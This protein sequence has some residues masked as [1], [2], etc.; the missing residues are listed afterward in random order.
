MNHNYLRRYIKTRIPTGRFKT[1]GRGDHQHGVFR[2]VDT[3]DLDLSLK[4]RSLMIFAQS[5]GVIF[6]K[7]LSASIFLEV[8]LQIKTSELFSKAI[9]CVH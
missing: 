5:L 2:T 9:V 3:R 8:S 6:L 7:P 1:L 4:E